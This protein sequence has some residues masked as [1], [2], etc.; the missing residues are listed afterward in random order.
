M[1]GQAAQGRE[2]KAN[3]GK[4][5][6][7]L[8][9]FPFFVILAGCQPQSEVRREEYNRVE[10]RIS[11]LEGQV[12]RMESR[13]TQKAA[14]PPPKAPN[15]VEIQPRYT[16]QLIGTSFKDDGEHLYT[17]KAKCGAAKSALLQGWKEDQDAMNPRPIIM[18]RPSPNCLPLN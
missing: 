14:P 12:A 10:E 16:H 15:P 2:A 17:S 18:S 7:R 8:A 3:A 6:V 4:G 13:E 5:K 11:Q 9:L 1:G